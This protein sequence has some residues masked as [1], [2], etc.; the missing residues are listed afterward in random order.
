MSTYELII[1]NVLVQTICRRTLADGVAEK[2]NNH[3]IK[4]K[5]QSVFPD[6]DILT[7]KH[8]I[9]LYWDT[10]QLR[11]VC[12]MYLSMSVSTAQLCRCL[13]IYYF[14]YYYYLFLLVVVVVVVP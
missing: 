10:C 5:T 8:K 12:F 1:M 13:C 9:G 7:N 3:Q 14:C 4:H 11:N 2:Q 6:L